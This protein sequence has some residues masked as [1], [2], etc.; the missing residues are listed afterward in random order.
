[1]ED[2]GHHHLK[3]EVDVPVASSGKRKTRSG[4]NS[5][6]KKTAS[7]KKTT[8]KKR[9][10]HDGSQSTKNNNN[11]QRRKSGSANAGSGGTTE[12]RRDNN[13]VE[14]YPLY[15]RTYNTRVR[16][17]TRFR[18]EDLNSRIYRSAEIGEYAYQANLASLDNV[19][20]S[21]LNGYESRMSDDV[22]ES[23][24]RAVLESI[25]A[26]R[27]TWPP[28]AGDVFRRIPETGLAHDELSTLIRAR[29]ICHFMDGREG[30]PAAVSAMNGDE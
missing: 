17:D 9:K 24:D 29:I 3:K 15:Q 12:P 21:D 14:A 25:R 20:Q 13:E 16:G 7:A 22:R 5:S 2:R 4:K 19:T 11:K 27:G 28:M 8:G 1:M 18:I 10:A 26:D 6:N 23:I 30:G